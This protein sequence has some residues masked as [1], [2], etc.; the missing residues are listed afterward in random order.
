M[1]YFKR[2]ERNEEKDK[3]LFD[4]RNEQIF[5]QFLLLKSTEWLRQ[6]TKKQM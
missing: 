2:N 1:L 5:E 4:G 6:Q 3:E